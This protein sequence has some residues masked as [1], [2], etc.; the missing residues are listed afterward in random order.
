MVMPWTGSGF[1]AATTLLSS[2]GENNYYPSYSPDGAWVVFNRSPDDSYNNI[3]AHLWA[4]RSSG[5]PPIALTTADDAG[6]QGNSW[7]K[8]APFAQTYL[9]EPLLWVT[10]SSRRDYGLRLQQASMPAD[11][12]TVQIWMAA[13]RPNQPP[14]SDPSAPAFWLPIQSTSAGNHIAQWTEVVVRQS[15]E[16]D[17]NCRAADHCR[18]GICVGPS[19]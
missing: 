2:S 10:V 9:G 16:T 5:G 6:D 12:R 3:A 17:A 14:P 13:F 19:T 7:P 11:M 4:V 8:W 18:Q 15:C 1:G